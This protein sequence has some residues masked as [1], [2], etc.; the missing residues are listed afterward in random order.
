MMN[1]V[2]CRSGATLEANKDLIEE[3]FSEKGH[4]SGC[5]SFMRSLLIV[6]SDN[7]NFQKA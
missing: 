6:H 4:N 1:I 5:H 7:S 3:T 2:N